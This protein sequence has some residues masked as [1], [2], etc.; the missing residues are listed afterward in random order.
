MK[1]EDIDAL[2]NLI[3]R[4]ANMQQQI[5]EDFR[6]KQYLLQ[7]LSDESATTMMFDNPMSKTVID[8]LNERLKPL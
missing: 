5:D 6:F 3:D 7:R 1:K 4:V 2:C 8:K